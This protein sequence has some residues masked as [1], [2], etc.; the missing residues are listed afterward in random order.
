MKHLK[1]IFAEFA[2]AALYVFIGLALG[3]GLT[4]QATQ[5]KY[6]CA[7][8]AEYPAFIERQKA[9]V[10]ETISPCMDPIVAKYSIA[11]WRKQFTASATCR[12][13]VVEQRIL[14]RAQREFKARLCAE[15]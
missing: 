11:E 6:L 12:Q 5:S 1:T 9:I 3:V 2:K 10:S 15:R 13:W 8:V 14:E 4:T 7:E